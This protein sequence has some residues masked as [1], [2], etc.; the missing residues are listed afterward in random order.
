MEN[1][2]KA[3][4]MAG[5]V[6]IAIIII[7]CLVLMIN[8]LS[9]Y[10]GLQTQNEEVAQIEKFNNQYIIYNRDDVRGSDLYSLMNK[11]I[12]YNIRQSTEGKELGQNGQYVGYSPMN[13]SIDLKG[14]QKALV[15]LDG[16]DNKLFTSANYVAS[17]TNNGIEKIKETITKLEN[18]E[19]DLCTGTKV[20]LTPEILTNLVT[21]STKIFVGNPKDLDD[22]QKSD[23]VQNFYRVLGY[24]MQKNDTK[25]INAIYEKLNKNLKEIVY[26]YAEYIQFKRAIFKC[27]GVEYDE[28]SGRI[29]KMKFEFTG[30]FN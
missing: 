19:F 28:S 3:L 12:D 29:I 4:I 14:N 20:I 27:T 18:T 2:S 16:E 5:S 25:T 21:A 15:Y 13:I 9:A 26:K 8:N 23:A 11:V 6:L 30:N 24:S 10:Q 1:A 17:G 22:E 7:S